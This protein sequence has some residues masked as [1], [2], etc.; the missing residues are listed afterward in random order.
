VFCRLFPVQLTFVRTSDTFKPPFRI[1]ISRISCVLH[2]L[3]SMFCV[4]KIF[5][6]SHCVGNNQIGSWI[7]QM[8][9][10]VNSCTSY[11]I[12]YFKEMSFLQEIT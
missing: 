11:N 1:V 2:H 12:G 6:H 5:G 8:L 10:L 3:S 7:D 9:H 4:C